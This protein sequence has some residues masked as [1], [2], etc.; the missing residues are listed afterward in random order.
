MS[1]ERRRH[2]SAEK[3]GKSV[4]EAAEEVNQ[5]AQNANRSAK[6]TANKISN[7]LDDAGTKVREK[8]KDVSHSIEK[9]IPAP[10]QI[11]VGLAVGGLGGW[12]DAHYTEPFGTTLAASLLTLQVLD[13]MGAIRMPWNNTNARGNNVQRAN[14]NSSVSQ[15][16]TS[17]AKN[18]AYLAGS[19]LA[20][21]VILQTF[22]G[23]YELQ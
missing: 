5:G 3:V 1:P 23:E 19:F 20:S 14:A 15:E 12:M 16:A 8:A 9:N 17:F 10:A 2:R 11:A 13:H 22:S 18:N 21:Y 6:K 7:A 4:D